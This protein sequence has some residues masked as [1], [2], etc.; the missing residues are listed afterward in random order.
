[1]AGARLR[2]TCGA[3]G[4]R[5]RP[6]GKGRFEEEAENWS[7]RRC[8]VTARL[9]AA[10]RAATLTRRLA[11]AETTARGHLGGGR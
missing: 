4:V 5:A 9:S 6:D 7:A 10:I 11:V 8:H 1:M 2:E 3:P